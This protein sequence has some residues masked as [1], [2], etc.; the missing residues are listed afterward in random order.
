MT[1]NKSIFRITFLDEENKYITIHAKEMCASSMLGFIEAEK[2]VF[3]ELS[4]II[5]TP[6]DDKARN[7]FKD[8]QRTYIPIGQ[9]IRIDEI[10]TDKTAPVITLINQDKKTNI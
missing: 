10:T 3:P 6:E 9:I 2:F 5:I 1:S 4:D 8:V 7:L